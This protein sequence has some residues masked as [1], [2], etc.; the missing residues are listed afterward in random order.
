M[1][2]KPGFRKSE[3]KEDA[4]LG[5][6]VFALGV[7]T[8]LVIV[9]LYF[10]A[11]EIWGAVLS[12]SEL[13]DVAPAIAA[14]LVAFVSLIISFKALIE[15]RKMRQ[16]GVD[17]VL[18]AHLTQD[19]HHPLIMALNI[20]NVGAGAAMNV[21]AKIDRSLGAAPNS[22]LGRV[23]HS[24][25]FNFKR[26]MAVVLQGQSVPHRLGTGPELFGG[27]CPKKFSVELQYEDIEGAK[28][29]SVHELNLNEFDNRNANEP[30]QIKIYRELEKIR[31]I[32]A[33][34]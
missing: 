6:G 1:T 13:I 10:L 25:F 14:I 30:P 11:K 5:D 18:I 9:V 19:P 22:M 3:K 27:T 29:Q 12:R 8:G 31:N 32:L 7:L 34:K 23:E 17:P 4:L 21:F 33:K 24:D 20:S 28:Y 16:A 15:Q 2:Q 26:P